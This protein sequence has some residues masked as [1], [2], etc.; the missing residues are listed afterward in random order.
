MQKNYKEFS[1]SQDNRRYLLDKCKGV[2][3]KD[4]NTVTS[5]S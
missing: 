3:P 4:F 1:L 5:F 2:N